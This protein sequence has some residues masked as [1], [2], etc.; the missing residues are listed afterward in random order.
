MK[1]D[2]RHVFLIVDQKYILCS[3]IFAADRVNS[4]QVRQS[5]HSFSLSGRRGQ[6]ISRDAASPVLR[7]GQRLVLG[8]GLAKEWR[9]KALRTSTDTAA[10]LM[11]M[12]LLPRKGDVRERT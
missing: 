8:L 1:R 11:E 10:L 6:T 4:L 5:F 7:K 12:A 3:V 2:V 9:R